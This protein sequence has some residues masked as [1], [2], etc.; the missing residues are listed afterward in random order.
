ML[1][2]TWTNLLW[3][4][5][6]FQLR[7]SYYANRLGSNNETLP[8]CLYWHVWICVH[9]TFVQNSGEQSSWMLYSLS[10]N[11]HRYVNSSQKSNLHVQQ[12]LKDFKQLGSFVPET[13]IL[14]GISTMFFKIYDWCLGYFFRQQLYY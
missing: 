6:F 3:S 12:Q 1:L 10:N 7:F 13:S 9:V 5:M 8:G 4:N 2:K 14:Q 11:I